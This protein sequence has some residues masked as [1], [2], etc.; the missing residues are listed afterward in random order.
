MTYFFNLATDVHFFSNTS[1]ITK[2]DP[3][4]FCEFPS[5]EIPVSSANISADY[6]NLFLTRYSWI[7]K[8]SSSFYLEVN[9]TIFYSFC[10]IKFII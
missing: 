7:A 9:P 2:P 8:F 4:L 5:A 10:S 1:F 6:S 3:P